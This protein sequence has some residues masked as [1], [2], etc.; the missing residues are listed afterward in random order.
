M[1][2]HDLLEGGH[3]GGNVVKGRESALLRGHKL[4]RRAKSA[5]NPSFAVLLLIV[6]VAE[7]DGR[8]VSYYFGGWEVWR[9]PDSDSSAGNGRPTQE[10]WAGHLH[11]LPANWRTVRGLP[12]CARGMDPPQV[13]SLGQSPHV[14]CHQSEMPIGTHSAGPVPSRF[15]W[16][17]RRHQRSNRRRPFHSDVCTTS[18]L[19]G[20]AILHVR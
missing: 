15:N 2:T 14:T 10:N 4:R 6:P 17:R 3:L 7:E 5:R 1:V 11:T 16:S 13:W 19:S 18:A 20:D 8:E 9:E 12:A